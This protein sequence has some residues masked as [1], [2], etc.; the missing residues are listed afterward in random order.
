M[1][2]GCSTAGGRQ[3]RRRDHRRDHV[4]E[5]RAGG[6]DAARAGTAER[7]LGDRRRLD[8]DR[9]E[10]A[11][12]AGQRVV[13][14]EERGMD[15]HRD[16]A[17]DPLRRADQLQRQA[18]LLGVRDVVGGDA[19]DAL[20][21]DLVEPHRRAEGQPREDRHLRRRVLAGHVLG[22]VGLGVA[23]LLRLAQRLVVGRAGG[24][25]LREDVVGRAV[26]DPVHALDVRGGERLRHHPDR[27]HHAGH[28]ALEAQLHPAAA[29]GVE[30]LLAVLGEQLLVGGDD[31]AAGL[32]ARAARTRAPGR[33]RRSAPR[34]GRCARGSRRSR[35]GCASGRP[36]A[37]AAGPTC[38]L[39]RVGALLDQLARTRRR[40]SRGRAARSERAQTSRRVRS[41]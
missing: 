36:R 15:V 34:P 37:R 2:I 40:P 39:D 22:R 35:R 13:G 10:R 19:L 11:V 26:D 27:R 24:G 7:D 5:H 1:T 31:V 18:E 21:A 16:A 17:V 3:R 8:R 9:V 6:L 20:V 29:G 38:G 23:Q 12:D 14:V 4:A 33:C 30:D 25:H 32:A 28:R 41:S